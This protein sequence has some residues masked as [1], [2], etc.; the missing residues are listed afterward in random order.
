MDATVLNKRLKIIWKWLKK[1]RNNW[2]L[3]LIVLHIL[4]NFVSPTKKGD[5]R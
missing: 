2:S 1:N 4:Q 3:V 5:E